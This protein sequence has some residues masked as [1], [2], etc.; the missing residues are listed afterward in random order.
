VM[1][2]RG[3]LVLVYRDRLLV[4]KKPAETSG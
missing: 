2:Q 4:K 3:A 1:N